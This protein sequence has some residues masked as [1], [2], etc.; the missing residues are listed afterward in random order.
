MMYGVCTIISIAVCIGRKQDVRRASDTLEESEWYGEFSCK[1]LLY[2][3][4]VFMKP[5]YDCIT[6]LLEFLV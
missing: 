2:S 6:V 5:I 3:V 1:R 4:F